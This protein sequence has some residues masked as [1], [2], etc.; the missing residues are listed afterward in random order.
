MNRK[1]SSRRRRGGLWMRPNENDFNGLIAQ[2][3]HLHHHRMRLRLEG[4][5]LYR[6]QPRLLHLLWEREGRTHSEL[7][8]AMNVQPATITKML[9]RMERRGFVVRK[10]D[11]EDERV[12]RVYLGDGGRA[13]RTRLEQILKQQEEELLEG[14]DR[15]EREQLLRFLARIR[16]GM[17]DREDD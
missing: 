15:E 2:I 3:C 13:V 6:G 8:E 4:L 17:R 7:A 14:F 12:S 10:Q 5:A 11:P 9:Q 1:K 16:D